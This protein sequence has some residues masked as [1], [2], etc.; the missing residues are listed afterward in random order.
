M[1][2][3]PEENEYINQEDGLIYCSICKTPK[4][5]IYPFMGGYKRF[6]IACKCR[7]EEMERKKLEEEKME[8]LRRIERLRCVGMQDERMQQY[9]FENDKG[10]CSKMYLARNYVDN[11]EKLKH[12]GRG[13]LLWGPTGAG[14]TFFAACIANALIE[15]EISVYMTNFSTVINKLTGIFSDEK[16]AFISDISSKELL[17]IDDLGIE[18]STEYATE[19][20][21]N[22]IDTRYR[23]GKPMIVTTNISL[24]DLK[25]PK[26]LMHKRI[27][28]RVLEICAPVFLGERNIR[29]IKMKEN[30]EIVNKAI[31][32]INVG[33]KTDP[34][35]NP[36]D[37]KNM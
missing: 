22:V 21:Y 19:Q 18:R 29:D 36:D 35:K 33:E 23:S 10:Y 5:K 16:N 31:N 3:E 2:R 11:F 20:V 13:L 25:N 12:E 9:T 28:D 37:A 14:K 1:D 27:F 24:N 6:P 34:V 8:R 17:V 4:E 26:D 32:A 15:R 30:N 7:E